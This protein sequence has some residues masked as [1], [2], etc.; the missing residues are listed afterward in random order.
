M[1]K[2]KETAYVCKFAD[3]FYVVVIVNVQGFPANKQG[4]RF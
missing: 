1:K 4:V 2:A 3:G